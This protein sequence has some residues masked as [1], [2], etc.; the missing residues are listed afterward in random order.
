MKK[1]RTIAQ[2][3]DKMIDYDSFRPRPFYFVNSHAPEDFTRQET[4]KSMA[5]VKAAGFG[6]IVLMN[7]PSEGFGK[8]LYLSDFWFEITENFILSCRKY[9]LDF[10]FMDGWCCPPGDAGGRIEA[11]A[12]YLKQQRL[13]RTASGEI[14]PVDTSWG[15]PAFEEPE[16]SKLFIELVYEQ[17][18]RHLGQYF[19]NGLTGIFSD[20]DNRRI[21]AFMLDQLDGQYYFPWSRNFSAGFEARYG[22]RI[23]PHLPEIMALKGGQAAVDYWNYASELYFQWHENNYRWCKAHNLKYTWHTSDTGPFS[24]P[25]CI[26]SSVYTEGNP[27]KN[28]AHADYPGVDHEARVLD[29]GTHFDQRLYRSKSTFGGDDSLIRSPNFHKTK[30]DL[31]AKYVASAAKLLGKERAMCEL[32]AGTNLGVPTED[33]RMIAAWQILQG[34]NFTVPHALHHRFRNRAKLHGAPPEQIVRAGERTAKALNDFIGKYS[35]LISQGEWTPRA[36]VVDPTE[37][38]LRGEVTGE[39][40][41]ELCDRLNK[42]NVDHIILPEE[43]AAKYEFVF[44]PTKDGIPETLPEPDFTF[45]GT[46]LL[47]R[48]NTLASGEKVLFVGNIWSDEIAVGE[49]TFEGRTVALELAPGEIAVINGPFEEFRAPADRKAKLTVKLPETVSFSEDNHIPFHWNGSWENRV[50]LPDM[51]LAIPLAI[52][53][54]AT[55]DGVPLSGGDLAPIYDDFYYFFTV[56]GKAGKHAFY[57]PAWETDQNTDVDWRPVAEAKVS[58]FPTPVRLFGKFDVDLHTHNDFHRPVFAYYN[59][60]MHYPEKMEI[61]LDRRSGKMSGEPFYRGSITHTIDLE[62]DF[63]R[64]VIELPKCTG[65][66]ELF[67]DGRSLGTCFATPYRYAAGKLTGKHRLEIVTESLLTGFFEEYREAYGPLCDPLIFEA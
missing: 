44:D 47:G 37:R 39:A 59:L 55:F 17:Y 63:D 31:R 43:D 62:C 46:T 4:D 67:L 3:G 10:W 27:F 38:L 8:E 49:L 13:V 42:H 15:F 50:D 23:E 60:I 9:G 32:F 61:F 29:G 25:E 33:L 20:T 30:Y 41:F 11:A 52:A 45:T 66:V 36:A 53:A 22:Y 2:K 24:L 6:G 34:I 51:R 28:F 56:S 40:F 57:L 16:S 64:A 58:D 65:T 18:A 1:K 21:T 19:G 7:T 48:V 14:K 54:G 35:A 26:R 12:P 5:K